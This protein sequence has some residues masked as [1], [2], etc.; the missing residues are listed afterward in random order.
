MGFLRVGNIIVPSI[1][2]SQSC[3]EWFHDDADHL[4]DSPSA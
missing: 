1:K 3:S 4:R 2:A